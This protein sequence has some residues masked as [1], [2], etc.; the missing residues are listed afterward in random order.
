LV[1]RVE[2]VF[3]IHAETGLLLSHVATPGLKVDAAD[4][5][6][7]MVTA[8]QDFTRDSFRPDEGGTLRRF[9][10]GDH[11]VLVEPGPQALIAAVVRGEPPETLVPRLQDALETIH[12][13]L[14]NPLI[15]FR[16][17]A[18]PFG[19]AKPLLVSCLETVLTTDRHEDSQS[20]RAW[21]RWAV[22]ALAVVAGLGG[23]WLWSGRRWDRAVSD[24]ERQPGLTIVRAD[25]GLWRSHLAGLRDP[26]AAN[27]NR[28]IAGLGIDTM[29]V[30]ASWAPYLSLD[31]TI[32]IARARQTLA[33]PATIKVVLQGDTLV[34]SGE[35]P[36]DQL[37]GLARGTGTPGVIRIDWSDV[38]PTLPAPLDSVARL[39][40]DGRILFGVGSSTV[41]GSALTSLDTVATH[42]RTL[43]QAVGAAGFVVELDIQG[44][45]DP[46]G[47]DGIN[48]LLS[49]QRTEA[50]VARLVRLG[51]PTTLIR[52]TALGTSSP[53][54]L[55]T[56]DRAQLNRSV[57]FGIRIRPG[58]SWGRP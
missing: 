9:N 54:D 14:A 31:S 50:V 12:L 42:Y 21:L 19:A 46:S 22:P 49:Q 28:V 16:G 35:A 20:G 17:D 40:A 4:L 36:V 30:A 5:I 32:V 7:G 47:S 26:L 53:L 33:L 27:P 13:Q 52:S 44:R 37:G 15:E 51:L 38:H 2:Q 6:S 24:L 11:T 8:I 39:L 1:Y 34:L 45:A 48:L 23:W 41:G 10:V 25:R 18:A 29:A 58:S 57:S 3:L 56:A 55:A 43:D